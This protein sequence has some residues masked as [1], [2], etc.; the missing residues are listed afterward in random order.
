[1]PLHQLSA[2]LDYLNETQKAENDEIAR[3]SR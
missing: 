1:M 3:L 2:F